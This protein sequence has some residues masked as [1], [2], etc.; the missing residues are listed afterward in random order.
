[1]RVLGPRQGNIVIW[2]PS[3]SSKR[4]HITSNTS[5]QAHNQN[6]WTKDGGEY[7]SCVNLGLLFTS[8]GT[9]DGLPVSCQKGQHYSWHMGVWR[10]Q[11]YCINMLRLDALYDNSMAM[12]EF[13]SSC[14][15]EKHGGDR[16]AKAA[17]QTP[18]PGAPKEPTYERREAQLRW[19]WESAKPGLPRHAT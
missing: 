9:R 12:S 6:I 16:Q 2:S 18:D 3:Q 13:A 17:A 11:M 19:V 4:T 14:G 15:R 5:C 10:N 7:A 8:W 1:M